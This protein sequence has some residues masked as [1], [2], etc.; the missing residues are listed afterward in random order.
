MLKKAVV[1]LSGGL[2]STT[3]L[4]IARDAGYETYAMS[5]RY[6]Q[7]HTVELQFAEK[8]AKALGVKQHVIVDIDL[9]IFGGSALTAD[10]EVPKDRVASEM[11]DSIPITYVPARNT[12]FLSYALAWAEVLVA[13]TIFIGANAIDYSG[14]PDCRPEYID[15]Y[16]RMANLATQAGVE[17]KTKLEIRAPLINKTKAEIIQM[18]VALGV[19]YSLTFSCY[20]PDA[21]GS[22]CGGCDSCLLRK[23]GFKEAG[24]SDPTRYMCH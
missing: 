2:D 7:R 19:D 22:A 16:Q 23:R 13:D 4:A 6:G 5:F 12:I 21:E 11:D 9:R 14:Y 15:A 10:I 3:T 20:D 24:I 17:G 18:G 1:L 8:A